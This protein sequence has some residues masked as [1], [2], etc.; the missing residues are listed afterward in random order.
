[1]GKAEEQQGTTETL[2]WQGYGTPDEKA[3]CGSPPRPAQPGAT[4]PKSGRCP[5]LMESRKKE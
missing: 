1:M 3:V 2:P 4:F 5:A